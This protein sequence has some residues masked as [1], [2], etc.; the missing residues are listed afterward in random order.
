MPPPSL[1]LVVGGS[2]CLGKLVVRALLERG[3]RVRVMTRLPAALAD[4]KAAGVD[5]VGGDLLDVATVR[6][7]CLGASRVV[8]SAHSLVGA[9]KNGS[10]NVDRAGHLALV[11][12]ARGS[13]V[14]RFVYVSSFGASSDHVIPFARFKAVVEQ[15]L[16]QSDLPHT[17]LR[18]T[19]F[20]D[21]HAEELIG[22]RMRAGQV[23]WLGGQANSPQNFVAAADVA[24][25]VLL[26]L[27]SSRA[28]SETIE[29]GGPEN[30]TRLD[31]VRYYE[32]SLAV[33]ARVRHIPLPVLRA[34][35]SVMARVHEGIA[36]ALLCTLVSETTEQSFDC[37]EMIARHGIHPTPL[38]TWLTQR[39]AN[40]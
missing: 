6:R 1:T 4:M 16:R 22:R 10:D 9:G 14:R 40:R 13:G 35:R 21:F 38:G 17:I 5:V 36:Q 33:Q 3:E 12:A 30:L 37:R 19:L 32:R 34:T 2:G 18:P 7:A 20:M 39:A 26:G 25:F 8:A 27:D 29:I 23:V 31:V 28:H 11:E 15:H 24:Q